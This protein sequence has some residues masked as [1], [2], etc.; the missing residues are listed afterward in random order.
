MLKDAKGHRCISS[1]GWDELG[2]VVG[3]QLGEK[4]KV[5]GRY[6]LAEKLDALADE[7]GHGGDLY[8]RRMNAGLL[9]E[10]LEK[11]LKA[12]AQLVDGQGANMLGVEPDGLGIEGVFFSKVD[13]GIGAV[14][15]LLGESCGELV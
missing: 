8:G 15:A 3:G 10:G 5:R 13:D 6:G 2:R 9:E 14:D 11:G 1:L 4:E 7:R 12:A